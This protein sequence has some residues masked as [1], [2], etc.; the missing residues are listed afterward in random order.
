MPKVISGRRCVAAL[1]Y[2]NGESFST[3]QFFIALVLYANA[4]DTSPFSEATVAY[5][6]TEDLADDA[7]I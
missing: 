4:T 3:F 5:A 2:F 6:A 7:N 1:M